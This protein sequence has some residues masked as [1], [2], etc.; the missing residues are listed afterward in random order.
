MASQNFDIEKIAQLA[1]LDLSADEKDRM[2]PQFEQI[3]GYI[4]QLSALNTDNV[5]PTSHVLPITNVLREDQTRP[6]PADKDYLSL[7]PRSD[8]GHYEVPQII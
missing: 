8:K 4:D 3:L 7:A 5:E 1:R 6:R 2:R